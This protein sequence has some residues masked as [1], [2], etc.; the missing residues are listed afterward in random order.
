MPLH[1][2]RSRAVVGEN[3]AEM[4]DAGHPRKQAIAAALRSAGKSRKRKNAKRKKKD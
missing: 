3:I 2:G 4:E 1:K